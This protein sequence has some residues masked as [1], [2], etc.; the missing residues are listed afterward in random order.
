MKLAKFQTFPNF[1]SGLFWK[2]IDGSFF[3]LKI[4]II[5]SVIHKL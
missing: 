4:F 1:I 5:F 3:F 2:N